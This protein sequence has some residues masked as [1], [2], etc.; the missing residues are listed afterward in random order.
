[1]LLFELLIMFNAVQ[2]GLFNETGVTPERRWSS[3]EFNLFL[4]FTE[5]T[6]LARF[7]DV[8]LFKSSMCYEAVSMSH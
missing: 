7:N 6:I 8:H 5:F 3:Q 2:K 4:T 1:M